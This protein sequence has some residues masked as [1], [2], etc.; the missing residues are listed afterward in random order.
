LQ[1]IVCIGYIKEKSKRLKGLWWK[2]DY[3]FFLACHSR[4]KEKEMRILAPICP[5]S[6]PKSLYLIQKGK[7]G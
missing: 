2:K 6:A 1:A 3:A 5:F 4:R 7:S